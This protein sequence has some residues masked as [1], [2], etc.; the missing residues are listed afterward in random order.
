MFTESNTEAASVVT[1]II[2]KFLSTIDIPAYALLG[3]VYELFFNVA[4][5]DLFSNDTIM[6]FY[7]RVQIIL[8]VFMMFHLALTILK[9]IVSPDNFFKD[10]GDASGS[11]LV[12]RIMTA[13]ILLTL[14]MPI[15][16]PNAKNEY[17]RQINNNGLLF[18]TLYSLQYRILSNNTLGRLILGSN[19]GDSTFVATDEGED[20]ELKKASRIFTSTIL[21]GFYRINLVPEE[22]RDMSYVAN[23]K[24]AATI[25]S[26]RV[27]TDIDDDALAAYT[28][29]DANPGDIIT[30]VNLTCD[31]Q[32]KPSFLNSIWSG[33]QKISGTSKY[34]FTYT[35]ILSFIVPVIF[36]FILLSFTIDVAVR[37]VKLAVLRLIAPIPIISYMDPK[38][39]K[40]NA[41][42][43]WVKTLT[44]TY[45]DLFIRLAA[46]YFVIFL[47]QDMIVNGLVMDAGSGILKVF[48]YI[49]IW[50]GL[51]IFAKQAPKFVKEVL[52]LKNDVGRIFGGFG[53]LFGA[54]ATAAGTVGSFNAARQASLFS[55]VVRRKD[56]KSLINRGKHL[57]AGIAGGVAGASTGLAAWNGAKDHEGKAVL[58]AIAKR[59]SSDIQRG[60]QGST[61]LGRTGATATRLFR[62]DGATQ[63]DAK[64]RRIAQLKDIDTT[65]KDLFSYLETKGKTDGS[66]FIVSSAKM[67]NI[68][69]SNP[70]KEVSIR[71]SLDEYKRA[72]SAALAREQ[73]GEAGGAN[74]QIYDAEGNAYTINAHDGIAKKIEEELTYAAGDEWARQNPN[75]NGFM[76]KR[77]SYNEAIFGINDGQKEPNAFYSRYDE[78]D[79]SGSKHTLSKLRKTPKFA[80][81][82]AA[83]LER[84]PSYT[85]NKADYGATGTSGT[86]KNTR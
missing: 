30:M 26:N 75:D 15:S 84:T 59:N 13:L 63:F 3:L 62:G 74:F 40:D 68:D 70:S 34:V 51:F 49:A 53:N 81:G 7:G 58:D 50:I 29:I 48:T 46:V 47:I 32:V 64:T 56:E 76:Q 61:F 12:V 86:T 24:D 82:D 65:A 10:S 54:V 23:G 67:N 11:N 66:S 20:S 18:G 77:D 5:A 69:A 28:R 57:L 19:E 55:D 80:G 31:S 6:K 25:N 16:I 27:C 60:L 41:F 83:R 4:S 33:F 9:G 21:K 39:A 35:P 36:I 72:L 2:R 45:L 85:R 79:L 14:L 17:E 38:G 43:S 44:S 42:S 22:E 71:S 78:N 1:D 8:G 73:R 52:G 37:A